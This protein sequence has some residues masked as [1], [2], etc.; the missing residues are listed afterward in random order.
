MET[1]STIVQMLR[2]QYQEFHLG[3]LSPATC[4]HDR[5]VAELDRLIGEC[6]G[7]I[8]RNEIG[9][10]IEGRSINQVIAGSG[11]R[12]VL[13]WSQMHGDE[14][15]A[16]LALLDILQC[17]AH[18]HT[19]PWVANIL[20]SLSIHIIPMVNPDGA[21]MRTRQNAMGI[22]INRDALA[23]SSPEGQALLSIHRKLR[24]EYGFNLHDQDLRSVGTTAKA[25]ALALLAPPPDEIRSIP[26]T[27]L[28]AM[29]I[30]ARIAEALAP[31]AAGRITRYDDAYEPRAF[32][33]QFQ[34]LGTST[35]L[36][37]SGH[38]ARDPQKAEIRKLNVLGLVAAL[39][40]IATERDESP[41]TAAY[42]ELLPNGNRM[43]DLLVRDLRLKHP[44]G[45]TGKVD[46]GVQF[47]RCSNRAII[48][49]IGDLHPFGGLETHMGNSRHLP[50]ELMRNGSSIER[51]RLYELL[52]I[53]TGLPDGTLDTSSDNT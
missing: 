40:S 49:E 41:G 11:P 43:F 34:A 27:R 4:V 45:W 48:K 15:T 14:S 33:D 21:Q 38:W 36:I 7:I 19:R 37:E 47:E 50:E 35:L 39:W 9:R 8:R 10:S 3:Y 25:A 52:D 18:D 32:G 42:D 1:V 2:D 26:P 6:D 31:L 20:R 16:T 51:S 24:P 12:T 30:G 23:A 44:K 28:R 53:P 17:F 46:L 22:D 29:C 5:L 13:L